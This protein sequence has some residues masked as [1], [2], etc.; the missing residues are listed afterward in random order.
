MLLR[1]LKMPPPA[2][3]RSDIEILRSKA[4]RSGRSYGGA[5]LNRPGQ[6]PGG[7]EPVHYGRGGSWGHRGGRSQNGLSRPDTYHAAHSAPPPPGAPGFGVGVPPPP[8]PAHYYNSRP[9]D[10]HHGGYQGPNNSWNQP[11]PTYPPAGSY[12]GRGRYQHDGNRES[13]GQYRDRRG[14]R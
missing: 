2:L 8:P 12:Q 11:R 5:P 14:Y 1:G 9:Q 7:R 10:G 13:G 6:G 3:T 4:N